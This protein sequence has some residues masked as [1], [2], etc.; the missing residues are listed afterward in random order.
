MRG[1]EGRRVTGQ[2]KRERE[3]ERMEGSRNGDLAHW[4]SG[5]Q[6]CP[7]DGCQRCTQVKLKWLRCD[8]TESSHWRGRIH[9][10]GRTF[11][12]ITGP[13]QDTR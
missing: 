2:E 10:A 5:S 11:A 8:G 12:D 3:K 13:V 1:R 7:N 6:P 9:N 4:P